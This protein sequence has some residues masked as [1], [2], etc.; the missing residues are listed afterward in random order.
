[1]QK[2]T[3]LAS[4]VDWFYVWCRTTKFCITFIREN[5]QRVKIIGGG[6]QGSRE[7]FLK[8]KQYWKKYGV[9]PQKYWYQI[10]GD[11]IGEFDPC[12]ISDTI[13]YS[14]V[15]P[16][17]NNL[18]YRRAYA[19]KAVL[20]RVLPGVKQPDTVVKNIAGYYYT[21][22][23]EPITEEQALALCAAEDCLIFKPTVDSGS[24]RLIQFFDRDQM[25]KTVIRRYFGEYHANFTAQRIL[26]QHADLAAIHSKSLNTIR[27]I[28]FRFKG[29]VHILS[30]Q[31]RMGSGDARIDNYSAGGIA[32]AIKDDGWLE[33]EAI[34]RQYT[35]VDHHPSGRKF[36]TIQ[37]P[38]Y[39]KVLDT[40]R[41][42]HPQLP[43]Y[44]I[45]GWDFA[46]NA[47]GEPVLIE[48]N[49]TPGQNQV[50]SRKPTFGDLTTEVLDDVFFDQSLKGKLI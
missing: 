23:N 9:R 15:L 36:S 34:T 19:D 48:F 12:F 4:M 13:W 47:D 31:L 11:K 50:G 26:E 16:Y 14:K 18:L 30:A 44:G 28:S 27:V 39:Q 49:L 42:L 38:S 20:D 22:K 43:Y 8:V 2:R 35:W 17:F 46:I 1:M 6:Y 24:G 10:Y 3:T 41:V 33:N 45:V 25:D 32:C 37:V 5:R 7:E 29:E 21:G 40:I